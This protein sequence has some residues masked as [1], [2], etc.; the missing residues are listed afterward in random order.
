M[1]AGRMRMERQLGFPLVKRK[2]STRIETEV[3]NASELG[4]RRGL[5]R[6]ILLVESFNWIYG[7][8]AKSLW[9]KRYVDLKLRPN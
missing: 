4:L 8:S 5:R 1:C 9:F 7:T 6:W 2:L 3:E